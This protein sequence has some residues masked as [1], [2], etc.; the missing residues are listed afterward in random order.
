MMESAETPQKAK[1]TSTGTPKAW[2]AEQFIQVFSGADL[3]E[4]EPRA[5]QLVKRKKVLDVFVTPG[6]IVAK[7]QDDNGTLNKVTLEIELIDEDTWAQIYSSLAQTVY[8]PAKLLA[9]ELPADIE[10]VFLDAGA[11][12][13]PQ[14]R[15]DLRISYRD[16]Q[17]QVLNDHVAALVFRIGR[18][19]EDDPFTMLLWR[20][21]GRD[22]TLA[23]IRNLRRELK[24]KSLLPKEGN[25]QEPLPTTTKCTDSMQRF[26]EAGEAMRDLEYNIKADEL[27]AAILKWLDPLPLAG[28]EEDVE[29]ALEEAYARVAR[30]AQA[31]GIGL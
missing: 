13:F 8:Y 12:L 19:L 24:K 15:D 17:T 11:Q 18:I 20:G 10:K 23:T 1:P 2:G 16:R 27:P 31:Y 28:L 25:L 6:V 7:V 26:W 9:G 14:S 30:R 4:I 22:E 21:K 29:F 3:A 5:L